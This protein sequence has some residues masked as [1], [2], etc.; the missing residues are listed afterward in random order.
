[1]IAA[2]GATAYVVSL[3]TGLTSNTVESDELLQEPEGCRKS[4]S[5]SVFAERYNRE[6]HKTAPEHGAPK[7]GKKCSTE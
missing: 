2:E 3:V 6:R 4:P 7:K 1:M 5:S